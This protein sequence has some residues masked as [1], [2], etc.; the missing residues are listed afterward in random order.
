MPAT[1]LLA[2]GA[3]AW[4]GVSP[5][6]PPPPHPDPVFYFLLTTLSVLRCL[7]GLGR[8]MPRL[9]EAPMV[10]GSLRCVYPLRY[11]CVTSLSKILEMPCRPVS[12]QPTSSAPFCDHLVSCST[13][14]SGLSRPGLPNKYPH[15]GPL[16]PSRCFI[17]IPL[18]FYRLIVPFVPHTRPSLLYLERPLAVRHLG[19]FRL[20]AIRNCARTKKKKLIDLQGIRS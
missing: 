3:S 18:W 15:P 1:R 6:P 14:P 11:R 2:M 13:R 5:P 7:Q 19:D 4:W 20:G 17:I 12:F 9:S 10:P 16:R 8:E